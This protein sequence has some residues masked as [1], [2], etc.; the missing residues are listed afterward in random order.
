MSL[1]FPRTLK[2]KSASHSSVLDF[3]VRKVLRIYFYGDTFLKLCFFFFQGGGTYFLGS[4]VFLTFSYPVT[5]WDSH[6]CTF[7][8]MQF[9]RPHKKKQNSF[10]FSIECVLDFHVPFSCTEALHS[11]IVVPF[12]RFI[13][14]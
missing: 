6:R 2:I 3:R 14:G 10:S 5:Y 4:C 7:A 12:V 11:F 13:H 1:L 8:A 9:F